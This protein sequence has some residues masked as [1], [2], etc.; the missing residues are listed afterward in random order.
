MARLKGQA[1]LDRLEFIRERER[2][3]FDYEGLDI[4]PDEWTTAQ[5][6]RVSRAYNEAA[7][8]T[9]TDELANQKD[10]KE[11][12]K[13]LRPFA[14]EFRAAAGYR[15]ADVDDWTPNQKRQL[16]RYYKKGVMLAS[17]S[18]QPYSSSDAE[19]MREVAELAGQK[20]FPKFN[21]VFVAAPPNT[22]LH[23]DKRTG[24][25][26]ATG[27]RT[28][29]TAFYW[30]Q[31]GVTEDQLTAD[32]QGTVT[33]VLKQI[34]AAKYSIKAGEYS[35][36]KGVPLIYTPGP[37]ARRVAQLMEKYSKDEFDPTDPNS[38]YW[39]NW[40]TGVDSYEFESREDEH[41]L[42]NSLRNES[43]NRRRIKR[44]S[45]KKLKYRARKK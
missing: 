3:G 32:P 43:E 38:H 42:I 10:Y 1:Y 13:I 26:T 31:F 6:K 40:L 9:A 45:V 21:Q 34:G 19:S 30:D 14:K 20:G 16:T 2:A 27:E 23:Y 33:A 18:F 5:K 29:Q 44:A 11:M 25:I 37:A 24:S 4:P 22:N 36:G 15:L 28:S 8:A 39:G 41:D 12:A 17:K 35:V 7:L